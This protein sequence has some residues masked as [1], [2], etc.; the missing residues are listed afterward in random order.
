ME[1]KIR[2]KRKV[3]AKQANDK[4]RGG[5]FKSIMSSSRAAPPPWRRLPEHEPDPNAEYPDTAEGY[6]TYAVDELVVD[7]VVQLARE[8]RP[9][10][11]QPMPK[12]GGVRGAGGSARRRR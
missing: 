6:A 8:P 2:A 4:G 12:K 11:G 1:E 10:P 7:R 5:N 9:K 3:L